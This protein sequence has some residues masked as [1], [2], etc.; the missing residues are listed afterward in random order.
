M[1]SLALNNRLAENNDTIESFEGAFARTREN[2]GKLGGVFRGK[3]G[4]ALAGALGLIGS[5]IPD[6]ID[7]ATGADMNREKKTYN[8]EFGRYFGTINDNIK[9][10][11]VVMGTISSV[12]QVLFDTVDTIYRSIGGSIDSRGRK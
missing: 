4:G 6:G 7:M 10:N 11:N 3:F 2:I 12:N 9:N 5:W 1:A 8:S